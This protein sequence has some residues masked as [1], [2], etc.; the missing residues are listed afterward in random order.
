[1]DQAQGVQA[2]PGC[3]D[4]LVQGLLL[5]NQ[6]RDLFLADAPV[7]LLEI[8]KPGGFLFQSG[9]HGQAGLSDDFPHFAIR[10]VPGLFEQARQRDLANI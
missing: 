3:A 7:H 2:Q 6:H 9:L 5:L 10:K 1:M 8:P 4:V